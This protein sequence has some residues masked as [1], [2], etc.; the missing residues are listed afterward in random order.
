VQLCPNRPL[1]GVRLH[2]LGVGGYRKGNF[3]PLDDILGLLESERII[4][5]IDDSGVLGH[6][7]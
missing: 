7:R 1:K 4:P 2:L 6:L 5:I 3:K